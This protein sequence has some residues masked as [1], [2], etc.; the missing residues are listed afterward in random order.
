MRL[1]KKNIKWEMLAVTLLT[2][3]VLSPAISQ[4]SGTPKKQ[5]NGPPPPVPAGPPGPTVT[6]H[7]YT[8]PDPPELQGVLIVST[9]NANA[10]LGHAFY[11]QS[12]TLSADPAKNADPC[13]STGDPI[14]P[15]TGTKVEQYT[16]FAVPIEMG[17]K[18]ERFYNSLVP[19]YRQWTDSFS[20]WLDISC[21]LTGGN[22]NTGACRQ[23]TA[24]EPDGI[25]MVFSGGQGTPAT[26]TENNGAGIATLIH[27][28]D[29]SF[30][31]HDEQGLT[32]VYDSNGNIQSVKDASGVGW[33]F[34]SGRVTHTNGQYVTISSQINADSTVTKTITDPAGNSYTYTYGAELISATLPGNPSTTISYKY[35]ANQDLLSEVDYNGAPYSYT[36]YTNVNS[37]STW[38]LASGTYLAD[39]S[40]STSIVYGT[41]S[42]GNHTATI[43]NPLGN[44]RTNV[45]GGPN[46]KI[47]STSVDAVQDCGSTTSSTSYDTNGNPSQTVDNNGNVHTYHYAANGQLQSET[48]AYGTSLARTT[49]YTWDP[50]AQLNRLLS[51]TV[52]GWN[53]TVYSYNAQNRIASVAVTNLSSTG[54]QN[55][56]L[57]TTY[58]YSLY[59]NGMVHT[60][61]VTH[62]SPNGSD[63]D[64]YT[65]DAMGNLASYANG[66]GQTTTYGNYNGLG[67]VGHVVGPNGDATDY[68]YDPRGRMVT[69]TTYPNGTAASWTY[70]YDSYGLLSSMAAPDGE[71]TTWNRDSTMRVQSITHNDKDGDS[72]ES[73]SY[74]PAGN[75]TEQKVSRGS[76]V[77]LDEVYRYDAL[78]RVYQKLGQH[79]QSLTYAYDGNG[80]VVSTVDVVGHTV[81]YQYD[82]LDRITRTSESGGASP[83]I[84]G[85]APSIT[86]PANS[87]S[88]SF[89]VSWN[90]VSGATR[91]DL[92]EQINGGAWSVAQSGASLTWSATG[93]ANDTYGYRVHACNVSGCSPWSATSIVSVLYPPST[94]ALSAPTSNNTGAYSVSWS[95][96]DTASSYT[97][98]E[99]V[100]GGSWSNA[101]T[102]ASTSWSVAGKSNGTYGYRVQACNSSGCSGWSSVDS[103]A[104]LLPPA[105]AP[106]LT[107]PST[108]NTGSYTLTWGGVLTATSYTLQEQI[109]SGAWND[110]QSSS[111][112]SWTA[113]AKSDG[114]YNYRVEACNGGGCSPWSSTATTVVTLPP[115]SP[116]SLSAPSTNS[117]GSYTVSWS[118]ISDATSYALQEQV[119]GGAWTAV[120]SSTSTSWAASGKVNGTYTYRVESCNAGGC[121]AWS[122]SATTSV[123][124]VPSSAPVLTVPA[125]STTGTYTVSWTSVATATTY[126]LQEQVSGTWSVVQ[127]SGSMSWSA[128]GHGNGTY[129]YQVSACN[130]S[131]CGPA[132]TVNSA[133]V[134]LPPGNA[135][136][137]SV[138]GS[139]STGAYTVSWSGVATATSY[140]LQEQVNA[141][142]WNTVLTGSSTSWNASGRG[143][144]TYG[145]H[146]QACNSSGCGSWSGVGNVTVLLPP[147][148]APTLSVAARN[149]ASSYSVSWTSV[150]TATGYTLVERANGGSWAT[151]QSNGATAWTANNHGDA[152][153]DYQVRAC[154]A[155]GCS[156]GWS[157][158]GS[159]IVVIPTPIAANGQIYDAA[160]GLTSGSGSEG[161]GF[162][163]V[164]GNTWEV[165]KT[166][167]SSSHVVMA[168]GPLP[169]GASKVQYTWTDAG[170]PP[171]DSD[172]FGGIASNGASS[173]VPVAN[174]PST[175]YN[176]G[177]FTYRQGDHGHQYQFKVDFFDAAGVN[178][179][180]STCT[181]I[182]EV[183]GSL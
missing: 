176:T 174:N 114:T 74:D 135:P 16:D 92:Q 127:S 88:G 26:F 130:A 139:S 69:K 63:V 62:P 9:G 153:Y 124:H 14:L 44:V 180:S 149:Y 126:Q 86:A 3:A 43:T 35:L 145:Y 10:F 177:S 33:T 41:D 65:Y 71:V 134:L 161:I 39:N 28:V 118:S 102:G 85:P 170:V 82:A 18:Y 167:L 163:I 90:S 146:V 147:A 54:A 59:A 75:V 179:S 105:S 17:L 110:V 171:G 32:E 151:V 25:T 42:S 141:G 8:L 19:G 98:Q 173:P 36:I 100:G 166:T 55:Q 37:G 78:G 142:A 34:S 56:T 132:S 77:G 95:G 172:A 40:E 61:S 116:P 89:A 169:T 52:E 133:S 137:L 76:F 103:V 119:N 129:S 68:S 46:G 6:V 13:A 7:G 23:F 57:T 159:T 66:L 117:S 120:Q 121:S 148:S 123:L 96:V 73:F 50:D 83:P 154:N 27:N 125:N 93:K 22:P 30:I 47:S 45:Y 2:M 49:D 84:P 48:E 157:N 67:E 136:A 112:T 164:N 160:L 79:G 109:G 15:Q 80:N 111:V 101:Q 5:E 175:Q 183:V 156:S 178:V 29:G 182:A 104:V 51:V 60:I 128:T 144:A 24:Y 87:A 107:A 81:E 72:T 158:L 58:G 12:Q 70:A 4:T 152:T 20:Y 155:S 150:S 168:S 94:P 21:Q 64:T 38:G 31:V 108:D 165:Y 122:S 140:A 106:T 99:Q 113:A 97:L 181:L 91:Y 162:D 53:K 131:G 115:G 143:N 11:P 1:L 138:P